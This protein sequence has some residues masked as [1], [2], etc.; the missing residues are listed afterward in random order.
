MEARRS[1]LDLTRSPL[2]RISTEQFDEWQ[3]TFESCERRMAELKI[4]MEQ[5]YTTKMKQI[6][7][8][9]SNLFGR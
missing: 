2:K 3:R 7:V 1:P 8:I 6:D 5:N 9:E 4:E